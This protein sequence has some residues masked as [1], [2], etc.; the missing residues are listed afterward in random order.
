[1]KANIL[2]C[3]NCPL[4]C[5][6]CLC[7]SA[8]FAWSQSTSLDAH[9]HG[10]AELLIAME[11]QRIEMHLLSPAANILGFEHEPANDEQ[12]DALHQAEE[13]LEDTARLF[14]F[15]GA[16]CVASSRVV[17]LPY[18]SG[19]E[20]E[21]HADEEGHE[22]H[23]EHEA[24]SEVSAQYIFECEDTPRE[25]VAELLNY[26]PAIETL[27]AQWITETSQGAQELS[28]DQTTIELR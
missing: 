26:L 27:E 15:G 23:D 17:E 28:A 11:G 22:D 14:S 1:M 18:A 9:V 8:P 25:I 20:H 19:H 5:L 10:E 6:L 2:C 21:E 24:H 12:W 16:S 3:K 7:C 4:F 13:L